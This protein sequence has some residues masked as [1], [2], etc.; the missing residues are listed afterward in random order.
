MRF[1][2]LFQLE[3]QL[4]GQLVVADEIVVDDKNLVAPA[5]FKQPIQ[6]RQQL[7]GALGSGLPSVDG[8]DVAEFA[9]ERTSAGELHRHGG[10][11]PELE[12]IE[13]WEGSLADIGLVADNVEPFGGAALDVGGDLR[14]NLVGL[15]DH[16]VVRQSKQEFRFAAGER[17]ADHRPLAKSP[18]PEEGLANII[19]LDAHPADHDEVGPKDVCVEQVLKASVDQP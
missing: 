17:P 12:Q 4:E 3:R 16:D 13:P 2:P 9:L 11:L 6:L 5:K 1:L 10:I 19:L 18:R 15:A 7:A 14:E 8:D